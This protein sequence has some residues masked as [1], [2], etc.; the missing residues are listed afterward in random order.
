[1]SRVASGVDLPAQIFGSGEC[2]SRVLGTSQNYGRPHL[3]AKGCLVFPSRYLLATQC[4]LQFSRWEAKV[5]L[6]EN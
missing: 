1:M 3:Q 4:R 6:A 5:E 2:T